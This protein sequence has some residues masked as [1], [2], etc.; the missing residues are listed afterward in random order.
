MPNRDKNISFCLHLFLSFVPEGCGVRRLFRFRDNILFR[1]K[2]VQ[3][4]VFARRNGKV[5]FEET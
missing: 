4:A 3:F 1:G 5:L 2:T